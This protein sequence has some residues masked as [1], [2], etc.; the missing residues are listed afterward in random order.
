MK[1]L[2]NFDNGATTQALPTTQARAISFLKTYGSIHRGHGLN[3]VVSTEAYETAR[4]EIADLTS[5]KK[6]DVVVFTG[7]STFSLNL[8]SDI[9]SPMGG[10]VLV[11]DIEHSSNILSWK[12]N[13]LVKYINSGKKFH[14]T[15]K[16]IEYSITDQTKVLAISGASNLTGYVQDNLEDIYNLCKSKGIIFVID[17]SQLSPHYKINMELCDFIVFSG[18]KTYAPFGG[19]CLIGNKTILSSMGNAALGGG[20]IIYFDD[21]ITLYKDAPHCLE[22]GTPN[23]LGAVTVAE[24]INHLYAS[25]VEEHT[26]EISTYMYARLSKLNNKFGFKVKFRDLMPEGANFTPVITVTTLNNKRVS[27]LLFKE[28]VQF[29]MGN[30]CLYNL[31]VKDYGLDKNN[32]YK[33]IQKENKIPDEYSYIRFSGGFQTTKFD[34]DRLVERL[35]KVL[36]QCETEELLKNK[37]SHLP[38]SLNNMYGDPLMQWGNTVQ[39]LD[40]LLLEGHKGVISIITKGCF[41]NLRCEQLEKY[42]KK[43]LNIIV[44]VS[45][46]GLPIEIEPVSLKSRVIGLANLKRHK[47]SA[48][49][50]L[51]PFIPGLNDKVEVLEDLFFRINQI[52]FKEVIIS[53]FRGSNDIISKT[54]GDETKEKFAVRVKSMPKG[55]GKNL[56]RLSKQYGIFLHKRTAC[57]V[58]S[59]LGMPHAWNPYTESPNMAGCYNCLIKSTCFDKKAS[60][61]VTNEE[62]KLLSYLGYEAKY[63]ERRADA[64]QCKITPDNRVDCPSCCTTC[65]IL[66]NIVRINV[67]NAKTLGDLAFI[68]FLLGKGIIASQQDLVDDETPDTG[69]FHVNGASGMCINTWYVMANNT[70]KCFGCSYCITDIYKN[71]IGEV[72]ISPMELYSK[73]LEGK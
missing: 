50:Y 43:G 7:N 52:G 28:K 17:G 15:L 48:I 68:R 53:G 38:I 8:L 31:A 42:I 55:I 9:L 47:I 30:F 4:K 1:K 18:H 69:K 25:G 20:N 16:D 41:T 45:V 13:F 72:G 10:E 2:I 24:S 21:D 32:F 29:R 65:Y 62:L 64:Q 26:K 56:D 51:R 23:A 57:G 60:K 46:S 59:V 34:I 35:E 37:L 36:D 63:E 61:E 12:R 11:S 58:A 73:I 39:K 19:G 14:I 70:S 71:P 33:I 6:D 44:L 66:K 67:T 22:S 5:C 40:K 54:L 27:D 49:P 3:S